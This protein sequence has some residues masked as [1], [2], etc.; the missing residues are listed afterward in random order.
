MK[1]KLKLELFVSLIFFLNIS[2]LIFGQ[3]IIIR[4]IKM[5]KIK[6]V[7]FDIFTPINENCKSFDSFG[8]T[9]HL[10]VIRNKKDIDRIISYL[11]SAKYDSLEN[12]PLDVRAKILLIS[13]KDIKEI[14]L[15]KFYFVFK[16]KYYIVPKELINFINNHNNKK[17]SQLKTFK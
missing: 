7:N 5:I 6:N 1:N 16:G 17:V 9:I 3:E 15:D 2:Q 11:K 12:G 4:D 13:N 10:T 8:K 14:C